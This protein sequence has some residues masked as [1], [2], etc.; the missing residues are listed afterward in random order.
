MIP[1]TETLRTVTF[2]SVS[3]LKDGFDRARKGYEQL[4]SH[5]RSE[6]DFDVDQVETLLRRQSERIE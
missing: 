1:L 6:E 4:R 5:L 3:E 2:E